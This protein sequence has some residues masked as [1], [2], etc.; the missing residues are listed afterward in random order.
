MT[1]ALFQK[2]ATNVH[3]YNTND[4]KVATKIEHN[5]IKPLRYIPWLCN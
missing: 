1:R 3:Y 4:K 2:H 5:Q